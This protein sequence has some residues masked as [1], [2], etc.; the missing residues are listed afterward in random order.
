MALF[1]AS[2]VGRFGFPGAVG[3]WSA[4]IFAARE[5]VPPA[6][7]VVGLA[8]FRGRASTPS[9]RSEAGRELAHLHACTGTPARGAA[10]SPSSMRRPPRRRPARL[11]R[12]H[13]ADVGNAP[14][15]RRPEQRCCWPTSAATSG[16]DTGCIG[17]ASSRR[18]LLPT[19]A[20][21]F[22]TAIRR[23]NAGR[24]RMRP[25]R[26]EP[27]AGC[28]RGR[29]GGAGRHPRESH[30]A[31]GIRTGV[32]GRVEALLEAGRPAAG[33]AVPPAALLVTAA[34]AMVSA[35]RNLEDLFE[36]A[37]HL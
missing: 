14:R 23:S 6:V 33:R 24:T 31:A 2:V 5:P 15:P 3:H 11:P 9:L 30:L 20:R 16:P 25:K 34:V 12:E 36:L 21:P 17:S 32:A 27:S 18:T 19:L 7:G 22:G 37:R 29:Q 13:R 8:L 4:A 1:A 28:R 10:T 35:G 26:R